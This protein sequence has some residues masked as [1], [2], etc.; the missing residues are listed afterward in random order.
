MVAIY[1]WHTWLNTGF[2]GYLNQHWFFIDD[3]LTLTAESSYG[4]FSSFLWDQHVGLHTLFTINYMSPRTEIDSIPVVVYPSPS[5]YT[6][7]SKYVSAWFCQVEMLPKVGSACA[8]CVDNTGIPED[9]VSQW[10]TQGRNNIAIAS[11]L[12]NLKD[13]Y[14]LPTSG[15]EVQSS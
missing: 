15:R 2:H 1:D 13:G 12:P 4:C 6:T 10:K 8:I 11:S 9:F 5:P 3:Y 7:P 14:M